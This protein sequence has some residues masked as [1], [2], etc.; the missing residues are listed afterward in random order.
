MKDIISWYNRNRKKIWGYAIAA[1]LIWIITFRL[2]QLLGIRHSY[3]DENVTAKVD[4]NEFNSIKMTSTSSAMS[5]ESM[6]TF[7]STRVKEYASIIDNFISYCNSNDIQNA[8]NLI[9]D[10]CKNEQ[11]PNIKTF[12]EKYHKMYFNGQKKTVKVTNW[13]GN[14]YKIDIKDDFITTGTY[15]LEA[16][17][18]YITIVKDN[19]SNYRLNI[20]NYIGKKTINQKKTQRDVEITLVESNSYIDYEY[21]TF[22]V[23]NNTEKIISLFDV[24]NLED[25]CLTD[26]KN[27]KYYAYVL[28]IPQP[29]VNIMNGETKRIRIKY[30]DQFSSTRRLKTLELSKIILD[31]K[32]YSIDK[33]NK[34]FISIKFDL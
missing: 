19:E 29:N 9:S 28:E 24:E 22:E 13:V 23:K 27:L 17:Q 10:D 1:V 12:Q 6:S 4:D 20:N 33:Q 7:N 5:G 21:Y 2:I 3:I 31:Y 32:S 16:L 14:T 11:F 15:S 18:D 30:F 25:T 34:D 26:E 8:Y